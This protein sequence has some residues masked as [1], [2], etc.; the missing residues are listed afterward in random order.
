MQNGERRRGL[1]GFLGRVGQK[2]PNEPPHLPRSGSI[3]FLTSFDERIAQRRL[4]PDHQLYIIV[5]AGFL[6]AFPHRKNL[7]CIYKDNT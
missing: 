4:D 2:I 3:H 7:F 6:F 5:L 1:L